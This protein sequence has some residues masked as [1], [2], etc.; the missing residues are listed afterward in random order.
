[1][2]N[3]DAALSEAIDRD[4]DDQE[5]LEHLADLVAGWLDALVPELGEI[6][7]PDASWHPGD[8]ADDLRAHADSIKRE[9]Y[10]VSHGPVVMDDW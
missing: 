7:H 4:L 10:R 2:T 8:L 3:Y 5:R 6:R 9:L 1:M